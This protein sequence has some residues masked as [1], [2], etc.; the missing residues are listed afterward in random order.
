MMNPGA[1]QTR[2]WHDVGAYL[3]RDWLGESIQP[4]SDPWYRF[5]RILRDLGCH[6]G[7]FV[8]IVT[9]KYGV[10][11]TGVDDWEPTLKSDSLWAYFQRDLSRAFQ[12]DGSF[13]Y[14]SALEVLEHII[15]TDVFLQRCYT[16]LKSGGH[17]V[18]STPN[19]NSLRNR[20]TVPFGAYPAG[21]EHRNV[22]HHVRL[23]NVER[24]RGQLEE[25]GFRVRWVRGVS[26]FPQRL[27][28]K[29]VSPDLDRAAANRAPQLCGNIIVLAQKP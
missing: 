19:I 24:L 14:L 8:R 9:E 17:F 10:V 2:G 6:Q 7:Q 12:I 29:G 15:D 3:G 22:I 18:L 28:V 26:F 11:A 4:L 5:G 25:H 23:Y 20:L 1:S 13:D 27:L 21:L 16:Q